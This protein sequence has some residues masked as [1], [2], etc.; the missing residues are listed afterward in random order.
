MVEI[1]NG[2][3]AAFGILG[4]LKTNRAYCKRFSVFQ[5]ASGVPPRQPE[6]HFTAA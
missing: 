6:N 1:K 5:A 2:F 4:S 3:Q